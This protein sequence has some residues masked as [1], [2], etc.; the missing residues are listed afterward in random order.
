MVRGGGS[1]TGPVAP[2]IGSQGTQQLTASQS[3]QIQQQKEYER[4]IQELLTHNPE[5][6]Y[7]NNYSLSYLEKYQMAE[8]HQDQNLQ[9]LQLLAETQGG[10]LPNE[11]I[12]AIAQQQQ[13][14]QF[15]ALIQQLMCSTL[16]GPVQQQNMIQQNDDE[17]RNLLYSLGIQDPEAILN[18]SPFSEFL[19]RGLY[20]NGGDIGANINDNPLL[21]Q[22]YASGFTL[23]EIASDIV[24]SSTS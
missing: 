20:A 7:R 9:M 14:D 17:I 4:Y 6:L 24:S 5:L 11:L 22:L 12:Q 15:S 18:Q 3:Q 8:Q 13:S 16:G 10:A 2:P 21:K 1:G 23:P 19:L